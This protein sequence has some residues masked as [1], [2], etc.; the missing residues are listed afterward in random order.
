MF[1]K[2]K[3]TTTTDTRTEQAFQYPEVAGP[4]LSAE[5]NLFGG[6]LLPLDLSRYADLSSLAM[7]GSPQRIAQPVTSAVRQAQA[8]AGGATGGGG[9]LDFDADQLIAEIMRALR[10]QAPGQIAASGVLLN[11]AL[12]NLARAMTTRTTTDT[13]TRGGGL[14]PFEIGT[15]A[16]TTGALLAPLICWVADALYG[17][18]SSQAQLARLW[19][20]KGWQGWPADAFRALYRRIG[21]WLAEAIRRHPW[22]GVL[23]RPLFN[24]FVRRGWDYWIGQLVLPR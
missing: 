10:T 8:I 14:S 12:A 1:E 9:L 11:P 18:G 6:S 7:G 15:A 2:P 22:L 16:G 5:A 24:R 21:P 20:S 4:L 13:S 23:V 19:V 3:Q 17:E